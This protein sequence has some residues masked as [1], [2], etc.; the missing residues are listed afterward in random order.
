MSI[1]SNDLADGQSQLVTDEVRKSAAHLLQLLV[2]KLNGVKGAVI[3]TGDGF[4]VAVN[5]VSDTD[6]AKLS[7]MASSISA[8][9]NMAVQE[10]NL[11]ARHQSITIESEEGYVFIMDIPNPSCPMILNIIT[12]KS[13]VLGQVVY[14]A[15]HIV[16]KLSEI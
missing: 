13:A 3:T 16:N 7:A 5:V 15:K 4:E 2:Q 10:T 11:G 6:G 1:I 9:G 8:I 14:Y 12:S